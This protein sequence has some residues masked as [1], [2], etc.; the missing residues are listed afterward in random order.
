MTES[1]TETKRAYTIINNLVFGITLLA[2]MAAIY[3]GYIIGTGAIM[4]EWQGYC[5]QFRDPVEHS[6][7][8]VLALKLIGHYKRLLLI[9]LGIA[10]CL[11]AVFWGGNRLYRHMSR[12]KKEVAQ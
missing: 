7:C 10:L 1:G 9:N 4:N 3:Y 6:N 2:G 5:S 8:M 12:S 11:P